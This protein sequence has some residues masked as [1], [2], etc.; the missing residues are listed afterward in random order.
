MR[1][2]LLLLLSAAMLRGQQTV[3]SRKEAG[4][5]AQGR[6]LVV[7]E[8]QFGEDARPYRKG[9]TPETQWLLQ[10]GSETPVPIVTQ[11]GT[12][13]RV[14]TNIDVKQNRITVDRNG[15][16]QAGYFYVETIQL[17]PWQPL[18]Q[19]ACTFL[20]GSGD[21]TYSISD[22]RTLV[23]KVWN[24]NSQ[25]DSTICGSKGEY[26]YLVLPRV[27]VDA[28]RL[29]KDRSSLGSCSLLLDA[30]G[31]N[32][33][34]SWGKPDA[35]DPLQVRLLFVT[36]TALLAQVIDPNHS[37]APV[38]N[39]IHGDHF[40][41][42]TGGV[43]SSVVQYGIPV[44]EGAIEIGTGT[45]KALPKVRRWTSK[46]A[47]GRTA[48]LLRI[49]LPPRADTE[50]QFSVIYSQGQGGIA[51]KRLIG[52]SFARGRNV[53]LGNWFPNLEKDTAGRHVTCEVRNGALDIAGPAMK[54]L[55]FE[56]DEPLWQP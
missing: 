30:S 51:Q 20:A 25:E 17:S 5:D 50:F 7:I 28:D 39:W 29:E 31:K 48:Y 54:E 47:H 14:E 19:T 36:P 37:S 12:E 40:E 22:W 44:E 42:F 16:A 45:P 27:P 9:C 15:G 13:S 49:E 41:I 55:L 43:L 3:K 24:G 34:L 46:L 2:A 1:A 10:R 56:P 26:G 35:A 8:K 11:C 33:K 23:T 21:Y 18:S 6:K 38:R 4:T 32:G 52:T 53:H